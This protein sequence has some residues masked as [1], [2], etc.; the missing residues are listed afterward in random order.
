M[1]ILLQTHPGAFP[2]H[3][4]IQSVPVLH[5][6]FDDETVARTGKDD[7][8]LGGLLR[9]EATPRPTPATGRCRPGTFWSHPGLTRQRK[10]T[11]L[12]DCWWTFVSCISA[13]HA[14]ADL[15]H[16][17]G[18]R[19]FDGPDIDHL[20]V[21]LRESYA[22]FYAIHPLGDE[23][24][25]TH[26]T[27]PKAIRLYS[28]DLSAAGFER[29]Q[30]Q[31]EEKK[32]QA[33]F[34]RVWP[35]KHPYLHRVVEHTNPIEVLRRSTQSA[36][37]SVPHIFPRSGLLFST[38]HTGHGLLSKCLGEAN[39]YHLHCVRETMPRF[40]Q[41][42]IDPDFEEGDEIEVFGQT[43]RWVAATVREMIRPA[44]P[45]NRRYTVVYAVP[46]DGARFEEVHQRFMR[47]TRHHRTIG[48]ATFV[49]PYVFPSFTTLWHAKARAS[50]L[51]EVCDPAGEKSTMEAY[52]R[53]ESVAQHTQPDGWHMNL[54][55][56][57]LNWLENMQGLF[58]GL[59]EVEG[60][61]H[62]NGLV[63]VLRPNVHAAINE[64]DLTD[65]FHS[66]QVQYVNTSAQPV[67][68]DAMRVTD[69]ADLSMRRRHLRWDISRLVEWFVDDAPV[70]APPVLT[71]NGRAITRK[72]DHFIGGYLSISLS[73]SNGT[74][75][76]WEI[77]LQG[78]CSVGICT[79]GEKITK[80]W[81]AESVLPISVVI[82]V[83]RTA[84]YFKWLS[85]N[86]KRRRTGGDQVCWLVGR[87]ESESSTVTIVNV[88][89][90][91][92]EPSF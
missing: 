82:T 6:E 35:N 66:T 59:P 76:D 85:A 7:L 57:A 63:G 87:A 56:I 38:T 8:V 79:A 32:Y 84:V 23:G 15:I 89:Q 77:Q 19:N 88:T 74:C 49:P 40:V 18:P 61:L 64:Q 62:E 47:R 36:G 27:K 48:G 83:S 20:I 90:H 80:C 52:L 54:H 53:A 24:G 75:V 68:S 50:D 69:S 81:H 16:T 9:T 17:Y 60:F 26:Y 28:I 10:I 55:R 21:W 71:Q 2:A 14:F 11:E 43:G 5:L 51:V 4:P 92:N 34:A 31:L 12:L 42:E 37:Q 41:A 67:M 44:H 29:L 39:A 78:R 72:T 25:F 46:C 22:R 3:V 73:S 30:P 45:F 65:V 13:R 1:R 86:I 33:A 70:S 58:L 91:K